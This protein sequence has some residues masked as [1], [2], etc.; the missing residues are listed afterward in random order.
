MGVTLFIFEIYA[1]K[2]KIKDVLRGFSVAKVACY[3]TKISS[4][5]SAIIRVSFDT[6]ILLIHDTAL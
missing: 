5:C 4:S 1:T 2:D 6:T 3:V